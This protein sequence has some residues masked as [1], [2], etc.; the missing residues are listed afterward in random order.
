MSP[1]FDHLTDGASIYAASLLAREW[2]FP[3]EVVPVELTQA[4]WFQGD[5]IVFWLEHYEPV[6]ST[7]FV[8]VAVDPERR[9]ARWP[10]RRWIRFIE[11]FAAS[12]GAS[13]LGFVG[14]GTYGEAEGYLRRLGWRDTSFGLAIPVHRA[15]EAA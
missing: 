13:E 8:H 6:T 4:E 12:H 11:R 10:V 15:A 7:W 1:A 5:G 9:P 3:R 2:G 14:C